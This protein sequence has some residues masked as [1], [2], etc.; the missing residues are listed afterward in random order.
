MRIISI[1]LHGRLR[2]KKAY[3]QQISELLANEREVRFYE[4]EAAGH[5]RHLTSMAIREG[6]DCIVAAGGDG[7]L[8]EVVN[9]MMDEQEA[10]RV[11][12]VLAVFPIGS[13]NDFAKTIN[14]GKKPENLAH[15]L[16]NGRIANVD[17]GELQFTNLENQS[18][19]RH[20]INIS[21]IGIGG[22]V[23]EIVNNKSKGISPS[24]A[25]F[26]AIVQA[27]LTYQHQ[28]VQV[29][30]DDI[31]WEGKILSLVMAN[32]RYFGGGMCIAPEADIYDGEASLVILGNVSLFDYFRNMGKVRRGEILAHPEAHYL[33]ASA[34]RV[35][36]HDAPCSIDMDGDLIGYTP[37]ELKVKKGAIQMVVPAEKDY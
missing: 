5:A 3:R 14:V 33:S 17:I 15:L 27:F 21:D 22:K 10:G 13:G 32:G 24:L 19:K 37:L 4:T 30:G 16:A 35:I 6:A 11:G 9:G 20:F 7:T 28:H 29:S 23:A 25:Y 34:C 12:V 1:I 2:R 26:K 31:H 18:D 36:S 8:N